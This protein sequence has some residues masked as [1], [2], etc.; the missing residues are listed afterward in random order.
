MQGPPG[1]DGWRGQKGQKGNTSVVTEKGAVPLPLICAPVKKV[2]PCMSPTACNEIL[3]FVCVFHVT[4]GRAGD[5]GIPGQD[6]EPGLPGA[7]GRIGF[8]GFRGN[9]GLSVGFHHNCFIIS[10]SV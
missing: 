8:P 10:S 7:P 2:G 4:K 5:Q 9:P 3:L 1:L 6:G